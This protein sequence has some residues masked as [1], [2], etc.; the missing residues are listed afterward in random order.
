MMARTLR[1]RAAPISHMK[2]ICAAAHNA[3]VFFCMKASPAR[4]MTGLAPS[5][6]APALGKPQ[7]RYGDRRSDTGMPK[8]NR[9]VMCQHKPV[10]PS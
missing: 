2:K 10:I 7:Q 1:I 8:K 3:A 5:V 9:K 4:S 6:T